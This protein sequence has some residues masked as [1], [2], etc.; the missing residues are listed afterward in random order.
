MKHCKYLGNRK[1]KWNEIWNL[2][3]GGT[4]NTYAGYVWHHTVHLRS[5]GA[6][7]SKMV[8]NP[9]MGNNNNNNMQFLYSAFP[10]RS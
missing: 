7:V 1:V 8:C 6:R 2:G 4:S 3:L 9:K 10:C 5:F